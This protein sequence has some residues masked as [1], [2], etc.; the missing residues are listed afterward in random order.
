MKSLNAPADWAEML[1]QRDDV[2]GR[3]VLERMIEYYNEH[4]AK[5]DDFGRLRI[6]IDA[7][8]ALG[9]Q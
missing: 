9:Q 7:E 4:D 5:A 2:Q 8:R 3:K 6:V 1:L